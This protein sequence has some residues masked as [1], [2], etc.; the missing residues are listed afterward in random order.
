MCS[1][2]ESATTRKL[3]SEPPKAIPNE[4]RRIEDREWW[5]LGLAVFV[6]LALTVGIISLT[7]PSYDRFGD[8]DYWFGVRQSVY[9]LASVVLL[10]DAYAIYKHIQLHRTRRQLAERDQMF[11][12]ISENAADMIAVIDRDGHRLYNSPS[13][14]RILGYSPEELKA[15]S[16]IE[17]VHPDDRARI[18]AAVEKAR[19]TGQG[20]R[21]EYRMRH[22][23]G[24]WRI[25]ESTAC[26]I[27]NEKNE[28]DKFVIVNRDVTER[29]RS[30]ELL[31]HNSALQHAAEKYRIIFEDAVVGI[32]QMT[33]D[34]RPLNVNRALAHIHGYNSPEQFIAEMSNL[35]DELFVNPGEIDELKRTLEDNGVV[36]GA[37]IEVR[38]R[39]GAKKWVLMSIRAVRHSDGNILVHEGTLEDITDRKVAENRVQ[40]LAYYDPLTGLAN[41]TL[42]QDRLAKALAGSRRRKDKVA[43]LFIDLD[44]FKT[45]NDSLGHSS[46]DLLLREVADRLRSQSREQDTVARV[47]GDE[48]IM[49]LSDVKDLTDAAVAAERIMDMMTAEFVLQGHSFTVNCS[50]GISIFPEHGADNETLIKNAD[51]AMYSA[52]EAGRDNYRF[53]TED[54][55]AE[56][57]ER[58]TLE[59]AL[60]V[61][62]EKQELFLMYQPQMDMVTG[63]IVGWEA[64]LR[65]QH[66]EFGPISPDR[67]MRIAENTRL[68][69]PIGAWVLRTACSQARKWQEEGL[70]SGTIAVNVS[71]VQFRQQ[72]FRE[73]VGDVLREAGLA[74]H[75]LE[76][77]LTESLLLDNL[78]MT[79]SVLRDL[80]LM[81][82]KLAIDDFGTGY[83]SLSYLKQFP[84]SK[85]KIDRS[86]IC[87]VA[88]N[89]DDAAIA[90]AIISMAK[91]LGL[92]VIAEGVETESQMS[93]LRALRCDEIQGYYFSKPLTVDEAYAKLRG[94]IQRS[95]SATSNG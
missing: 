35:F 59:H 56:A 41:R 91:S 46:G 31:L 8:F 82:V 47:G 80:K 42:L 50:M 25:L 63:A 72:G 92:K 22:K 37:E 12:L 11:H 33:A 95:R 76:L 85:L 17:Q 60:R 88:E 16:S 67:F 54:M 52:K 83:S 2:N 73:L 89:P 74:P 77:E 38:C 34:G 21:V 94:S 84:F 23:D 43:L 45:I 68:I 65:W 90:T 66:P 81:G 9:A 69:L 40:F 75:F 30:E 32:F 10:F 19:L 26:T 36:R 58:L 28:V 3:R 86:F 44:R 5:L 7:L 62:L 29:K 70:C 4:L 6:T 15:T 27:R 55:N 87:D 64:L 49:V 93:F 61:A 18:L 57:T 51:A 48:F 39:D 20:E 53:F 79:S 78:D 13:Y 1:G 14:H 24:S 71:A